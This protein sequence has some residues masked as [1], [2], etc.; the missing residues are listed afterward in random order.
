MSHDVL[1]KDSRASKHPLRSKSVLGTDPKGNY[2]AP[3]S[4]LHDEFEVVNTFMVRHFVHAGVRAAA[5]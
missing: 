1:S 2:M 5:K 3:R 4:M